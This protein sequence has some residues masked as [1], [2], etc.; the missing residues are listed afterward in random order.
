MSVIDRL[1]S[2]LFVSVFQGLLAVTI[3]SIDRSEKPNRQL[4]FE[5]QSSIVIERCNN[6]L[7]F[8]VVKESILEPL[9]ELTSSSLATACKNEHVRSVMAFINNLSVSMCKALKAEHGK[10]KRRRFTML[11]RLNAAC[12]FISRLNIKHKKMIQKYLPEVKQKTLSQL[13]PLWRPAL[14]ARSTKFL[15]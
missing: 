2:I 5:L 7:Q 14:L 11:P 3:I 1:Q 8:E 10:T 4:G 6:L 13:I 15:L 9:Q 12:P